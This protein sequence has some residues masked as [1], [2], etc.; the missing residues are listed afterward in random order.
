MTDPLLLMRPIQGIKG[1]AL[2]NGA[3]GTNA[4]APT[5]KRFACM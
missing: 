2:T 1:T 5:S 4:T 3:L